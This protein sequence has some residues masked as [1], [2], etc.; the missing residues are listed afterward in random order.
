LDIVSLSLIAVFLASFNFLYR[1]WREK[2]RERWLENLSSGLKAV[3]SVDKHSMDYHVY[4][5]NGFYQ[6]IPFQCAY[7][8]GL[9]GKPSCFKVMIPSRLLDFFLIQPASKNQENHHERMGL[10]PLFQVQGDSDEEVKKWLSNS[11]NKDTLLKLF[12]MGIQ[13]IETKIEDEKRILQI[14]LVSTDKSGQTFFWVT[15]KWVKQ[16]LTLMSELV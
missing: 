8:K 12:K 10:D 3:L 9:W 5:L 16:S 7:V 2:K 11:K 6:N 13:R 4:N 1:S 14:T 15:A